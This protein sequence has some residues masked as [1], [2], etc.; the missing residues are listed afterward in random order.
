MPQTRHS[1]LSVTAALIR[2]VSTMTI[3][4]P[5][6]PAGV[7]AQHQQQLD[8]GRF[9]IQ[10]CTQCQ[11]HVYFPREAC[12]HCG[13]LGLSLALPSGAGTVYATTTVRRKVDQGGDYNVCLVRLDEGV[14]VM[15]RVE[16]LAPA[17]VQVGL[18]VRARVTQKDGHGVVVFDPEPSA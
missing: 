6:V 16:H 7:Q 11:A 18:R 2:S 1:G 5:T 4:T 17:A 3:A 12:P 13:A 15:A 14:Q 10:H 8:A 9:L